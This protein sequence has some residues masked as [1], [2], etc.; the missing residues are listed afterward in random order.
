MPTKWKSESQTQK[1]ERERLKPL[2]LPT[3]C[4]TNVQNVQSSR[5]SYESVRAAR[6]APNTLWNTVPSSSDSQ[7]GKRL[8]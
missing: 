4:A 8:C 5:S 6:V 1:Q 7:L 2:A 3:F